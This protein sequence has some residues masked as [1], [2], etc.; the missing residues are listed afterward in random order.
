MKYLK[1]T[2]RSHISGSRFLAS[3]A[4]RGIIDKLQDEAERM[5]TVIQNTKEAVIR[6]GFK[7][8]KISVIEDSN[9]EVSFLVSPNITSR[10]I[11]VNDIAIVYCKIVMEAENAK[12]I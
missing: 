8:G 11:T 10:G 2:H 6:W 4:K 3:A 1:G 7:N 9:Q 12:P 5:D